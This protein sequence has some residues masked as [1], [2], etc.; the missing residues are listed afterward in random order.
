[1]SP[2]DWRVRIDDILEAIRAIREY[3]QG[4]TAE[5]FA[6]D[7]RTVDA[8]VHNLTV[9]GEAAK[10]VP[11]D[12]TARHPELPWDKMRATRNVM[13]HVYFGIRRDIVWETSQSDLPPLVPLLE[14]LLRDEGTPS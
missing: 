13:V 12:V 5:S 8:V 10:A 14:T 2:R 7:Q 1:V 9:I 4:M 11:D 6:A 3:T